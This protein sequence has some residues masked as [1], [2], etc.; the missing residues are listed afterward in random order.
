MAK[1]KPSL[2]DLEAELAALE[3]ELAGL[4]PA[5]KAKARP[6]E[7]KPKTPA[8]EPV[9][10]PAPA[11]PRFAL[12][13]KKEAAAETAP[14]EEAPKG[15]P[16]FGLGF[17]KK[18]ATVEAT[19]PPAIP[20][21]EAPAAPPVVA[22]AP[23]VALVEEPPRQREPI[24]VTDA[25]SW[26]RDESGWVRTVRSTP[27][28]VMRRVLDEDGAVVREESATQE[29]LDEV[30]GVKAERGVGKILGGRSMKMPS[31]KFGRKH[32]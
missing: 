7:K 5:K 32:E 22:Q 4:E 25:S 28:P 14:P 17:G 19:P 12:G 16:K 30:T 18:K 21:V 23:A 2:D 20:R 6:A 1:D 31:F 8:P 3:A 26:R 15:K 24:P 11:K 13:R 29:D 27:R 10:E 9:A